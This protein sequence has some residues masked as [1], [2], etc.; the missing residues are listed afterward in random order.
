M[1]II[2]IAFPKDIIFSAVLVQISNSTIA[3]ETPM[4]RILQIR[5]P[6]ETTVYLD[7]VDL[8]PQD[9]RLAVSIGMM[10]MN[11]IKT[12]MAEHYQVVCLITTR[13]YITVAEM[14]AHTLHKYC[15]PRLTLFT[16]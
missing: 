5:G 11:K 16:C 3:Q 9:F 2:L 7:M 12:L 4:N 14:M 1:M 10:K 13:G 15:S 6:Q 8:V